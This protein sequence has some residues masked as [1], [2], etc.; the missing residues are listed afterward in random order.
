M[1]GW[2]IDREERT[3]LEMPEREDQ[4]DVRMLAED[5]WTAGTEIDSGWTED[6]GDE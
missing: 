2:I 3:Y 5:P 1:G 4:E 6:T